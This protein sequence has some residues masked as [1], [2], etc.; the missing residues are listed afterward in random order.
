[1]EVDGY[2]IGA[3]A[4]FLASLMCLLLRYITRGDLIVEERNR[5]SGGFS[6]CDLVT[7]SMGYL[8]PL[9]EL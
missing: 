3:A 4:F 6:T 7:P 2:R 9:G 8:N 5:E 1:V